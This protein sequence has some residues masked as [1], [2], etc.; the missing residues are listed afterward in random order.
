MVSLP[1]PGRAPSAARPVT[2]ECHEEIRVLSQE[3]G[4]NVK[5]QGRDNDLIER[6]R[7]HAYFAP[8]H[9]QVRWGGAR[10]FAG[11]ARC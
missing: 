10:T 3:A 7:K 11:H 8:I 6:I 4:N 2:Q 1:M 5:L 9:Q